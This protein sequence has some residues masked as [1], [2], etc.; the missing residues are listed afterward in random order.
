MTIKLVLADDHHIVRDG[1]K[2][3]L[4]SQQDFQVIGEASNGLEAKQLTEQLK[5]DV[6]VL[7]LMMP[8]LNGLEVTR[9]VRDITHVVILSMH[10]NEAYVIEALRNGAFGYVLKDSTKTE[11]ITAVRKA[12]LGQRYLSSPF[13]EKAIEVYSQMAQSEESDPYNTLTN[14]EREI[15]QL[16][17]EGHSNNDIGTTLSISPRTV[18]VHRANLMRKLNF[19]SQV[20]LIRFAIKRGIIPED[21]E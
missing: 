11:L 15:F 3:V 13:A 16:V 20:D 5:P 14:R 10:N 17:A 19:K 9:Q 4:E 21:S 12:A 7:D 6:L 2:L 1:F 18:E 8:M